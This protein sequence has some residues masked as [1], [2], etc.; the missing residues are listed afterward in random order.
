MLGTEAFTPYTIC[1]DNLSRTGLVVYFVYLFGFI[2]LTTETGTF[3][4]SL[5]F[6]T[7]V[8]ILDLILPKDVEMV[9]N[10]RKKR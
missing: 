9:F 8:F 3:E 2:F 7:G 10:K 5:D 4:Y 1:L 6:I